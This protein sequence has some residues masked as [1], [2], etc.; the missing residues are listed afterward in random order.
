[1][2]V[3]SAVELKGDLTDWQPVRMQPSRRDPGVW[4]VVI[5]V[6]P[7]LY[8]VNL[9]IDGGEWI[10]PPGLATVPDGFGGDTGLLALR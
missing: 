3:R 1:M 8:H 4:E 6:A 2:D 10:V 9:R 5:A 7:G